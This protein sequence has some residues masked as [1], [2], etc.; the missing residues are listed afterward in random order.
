MGLFSHPITKWA[1]RKERVYLEVQLRDIKN[2]N[3]ELTEH[4]LTFTG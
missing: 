4:T 1:Q 3:I 2:D